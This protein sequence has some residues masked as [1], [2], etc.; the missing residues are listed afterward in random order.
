MS[1]NMLLA[2]PVFNEEAYVPSVL[3][4]AR[5][6][7]EHIL[8][9]DDGSSDATPQLLKQEAG[10]EVISHA[11][12]AGYGQSLIDAFDYADRR[13]YEWLIT[14]D[15]DEQHEPAAIPEFTA[16]IADDDA[17]I[18]SG[19]RYLRT[20]DGD[21]PPPAERRQINFRITEML[22]RRFGWN[23]TDAF[24]GFKAYR[25]CALNRMKITE[26]GY[27][28]P[29]QF[30]AQA[31]SLQLRIREL[32]VRLVYK[33]LFRTFGG[34]LDDAD[35]RYRHYLEIFHAEMT[36]LAS[37]RSRIAHDRSRRCHSVSP[38]NCAA[39]TKC[40]TT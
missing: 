2:I 20:F 9:V 35:L 22:N 13:G 12:N 15:C 30:W 39:P 19:S 7:A 21:D 28:M 16:A 26:P 25:V 40:F 6:Y 27:A 14:M 10:I 36:R 31:A 17:D 38:E 29:M 1:I 34:D 24:C 37:C 11:Q 4:R 8:V 3:R 5:R 32:A 33:D 18:I 23:L